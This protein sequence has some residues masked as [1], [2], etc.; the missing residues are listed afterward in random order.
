MLPP[1]VKGSRFKGS[2][3]IIKL[4]SVKISPHVLWAVFNRIFGNR[5]AESVLALQ[6][7]FG[8]ADLVLKTFD[9]V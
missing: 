7:D 1:G 8:E 4:Q 3:N 2:K 6:R 9:K 5:E